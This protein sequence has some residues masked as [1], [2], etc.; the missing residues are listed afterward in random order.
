MELGVTASSF[1]LVTRQGTAGAEAGKGSIFLLRN[2]G[3]ASSPVFEAPRTFTCFG[4]PIYVSA[5]GPHPWPGD[6]DGDGLPDLLAC[7]EWSV[8]PFYAHAALE[9]NVRPE[10]S[11]ELVE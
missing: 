7:V 6:L 1:R 4:Q 5:H 3:T 11:L 9:M 10:F 8:Y 2:A